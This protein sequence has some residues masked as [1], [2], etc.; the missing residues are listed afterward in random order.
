MGCDLVFI[1]GVSTNL[2]KPGDAEVGEEQGLLTGCQTFR[3]DEYRL[4]EH[5]YTHVVLTCRYY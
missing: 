5:Q 1:Q 4:H 3:S 2:G